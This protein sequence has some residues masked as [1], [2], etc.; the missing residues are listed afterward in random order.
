MTDKSQLASNPN[1]P[2]DVLARLAE[3]DEH[4]I[5]QYVAA[6]PN[7]P[8]HVLHVLALDEVYF[9]SEAAAENPNLPRDERIWDTKNTLTIVGPVDEVEMIINRVGKP[10]E[11]SVRVNEVQREAYFTSYR[12]ESPV[13]SFCNIISYKDEGISDDEYA[14]WFTEEEEVED[15]DGLE[16][17][18]YEWNVDHWGVAFDV[19][20]SNEGRNSDTELVLTYIESS[21]TTVVYRFT[22]AYDAPVEGITRLSKLIPNSQVTLSADNIIEIVFNNG[23]IVSETSGLS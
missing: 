23:E 12:Y 8:A 18:W 7:T 6:N 9:V 1:T 11:V 13:F 2:S 19:A 5:R 4:T 10:F 20:V 16:K 17:S 22:T 14:R 3:D 21:Q 15:R